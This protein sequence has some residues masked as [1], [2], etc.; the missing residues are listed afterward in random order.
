MKTLCWCVGFIALSA[1]ALLSA[2]AGGTLAQ[3][4]SNAG[5]PT[6]IAL[7]RVALPPAGIDSKPIPRDSIFVGYRL[8]QSSGIDVYAD[9]ADGW[10]H[11]GTI[12]EHVDLPLA[13]GISKDGFLYVCDSVLGQVTI[14]RLA[15]GGSYESK[16]TKGLDFPYAMAFDAY[17]N[18]AVINTP[19]RITVF[20]FDHDNRPY[21]VSEGLHTP[22]AVVYDRPGDLYAATY[23]TSSVLEYF[24]YTNQIMSKITNGI[25]KPKALAIS[26]SGALYVANYGGHNVTVYS[27]KT[28]QL[29]YTIPTGRNAP[30]ALAIDGDQVYVAA[31]DRD[32]EVIHYN[33]KNGTSTTI[34]DGVDRPTGLAICS[35]TYLCVMNRQSVTI[36]QAD[37]LVH[38]I[39]LAKKDLQSITSGR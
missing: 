4:G 29:I 19:H 35:K 22:S 12:T 33:A 6:G 9:A 38:T 14:Y 25:D 15:T 36:Y 21:E 28:R 3:S 5:V 24:P 18:L 1:T 8:S 34:K 26:A 32:S 2:C 11:L 27:G 37:K 16:L 20:P 23:N 31:Y 7:P 10:A 39:P 30:R 13:I 17:S